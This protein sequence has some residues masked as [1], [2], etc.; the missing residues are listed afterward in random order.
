M[1]GE[2][3]EAVINAAENGEQWGP[4]RRA[5]PTT[6]STKTLADVPHNYHLVDTP[7][8]RKSLLG[9]L[10]QQ[11]EVSFDTETTGLNTMTAQLVGLVVLL[12]AGRGVLPAG[13]AGLRGGEGT[14]GGIL[15][16]FRE[17]ETIVKVGQNIKYDLLISEE[18][19]GA[20]ERAVLRYDAGALPP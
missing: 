9:Y 8:L 2:G 20:R 18:L 16:V 3:S 15:P 14:G 10:L 4:T 7:E 6:A 13:A 1:F 11:A 17:P 12:P 5:A 19:R